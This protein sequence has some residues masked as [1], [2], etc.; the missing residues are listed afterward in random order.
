ME[1]ID[2]IFNAIE[3]L[4]VYYSFDKNLESQEN[5]SFLRF[6]RIYQLQYLT[7]AISKIVQLALVKVI[8]IS[9]I[10]ELDKIKKHFVWWKNGKPIIKQNKLCKDYENGG[11]KNV[12]NT[13]KIIS[14]QCP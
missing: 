10:F 14:S 12:G 5:F 11:L 3:I 2:L 8:P 7:L 13:F 1:C 6:W 4:G 9:S